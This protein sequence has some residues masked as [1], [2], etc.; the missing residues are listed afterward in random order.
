VHEAM[1]GINTIGHFRGSDG[2]PSVTSPAG[3]VAAVGGW[4]ASDTKSPLHRPGPKT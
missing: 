3:G 1:T 2:V 4:E